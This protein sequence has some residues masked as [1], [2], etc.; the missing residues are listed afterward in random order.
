MIESWSD[1]RDG[2]RNDGC[3]F[4]TSAS[5]CVMNVPPSRCISKSFLAANP[6]ADAAMTP[7]SIR[8][9]LDLFSEPIVAAAAAV[10]ELSSLDGSITR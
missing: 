5:T 10:S 8:R 7:A 6:A 3:I 9:M 2:C 4:R 1:V